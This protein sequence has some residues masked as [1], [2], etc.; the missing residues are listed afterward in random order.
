M[1][2]NRKRSAQWSATRAGLL[3][4]VFFIGSVSGELAIR[5]PPP[6]PVPARM[7]GH[8]PCPLP[9]EKLKLKKIPAKSNEQLRMTKIYIR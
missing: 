4:F 9:P 8:F 1:A 7:P 6:L 5:M 2:G 3:S